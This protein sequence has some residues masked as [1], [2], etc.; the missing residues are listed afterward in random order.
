MAVGS[1]FSLINS[2]ERMP[3]LLPVI[4]RIPTGDDIRADSSCMTA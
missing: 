4:S 3:R 2:I 1:D